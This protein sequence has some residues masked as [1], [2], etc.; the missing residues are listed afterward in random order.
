MGSR[1]SPGRG[2][3]AKGK[4]RSAVRRLFLQKGPETIDHSIENSEEPQI[5][6]FTA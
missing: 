1:K 4:G 2:N 3:P 6:H 5:L